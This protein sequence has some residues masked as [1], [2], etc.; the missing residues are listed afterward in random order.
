MEPSS[1]VSIIL[2]FLERQKSPARLPGQPTF[3]KFPTARLQPR[4]YPA[5]YERVKFTLLGCTEFE[6]EK[7]IK[8]KKRGCLCH[9]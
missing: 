2:Q 3:P 6:T 4:I 1:D 9:G 5:H 8:S 7:M